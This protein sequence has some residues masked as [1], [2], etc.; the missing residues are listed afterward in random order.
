MPRIE[1]LSSETEG[2][3]FRCLHDER[4]ENSEVTLIRR[5]WYRRHRDLGLRT[6]V[7]VT[8]ADEVAGLCQYLPIEHSHYLGRDL[9]A[10]LCIWVHGYEYHLGN[11]QG[12]GYGR[13][14]LESIEKDAGRSGFKGVAVWGKDYPDWNPVSFYEHMGYA[15]ADS[16]DNDVLVWKSFRGEGEPPRFLRQRKRGP[17]LPDRI[18]I[19]SLFTGWC[20]GCSFNLEAREAA[21]ELQDLVDYIEVDTSVRKNMLEWGISDGILLDGEPYRNDG[22]PFTREDLKRDILDLFRKKTGT[23]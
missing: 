15:R 6:R 4:P 13:M 17:V 14:M 3:F 22:P 16:M 12:K 21:K 19:V 7:L 23:V 1:D 9:M 10:I 18:T 11:R 5:N 8:D 2:T 20:G